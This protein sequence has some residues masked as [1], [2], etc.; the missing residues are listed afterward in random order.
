MKRCRILLVFVFATAAAVSV[1]AAG[2]TK[3]SGRKALSPAPRQEVAEGE[4][5]DRAADEAAIRKAAEVFAEAYNAHDAAGVAALFAVEAEIVDD[6]GNTLHGRDAIQET[7]ASIFAETPE[8]TIEVAVDSIRFLSASL[9]VEFGSTS[10]TPAPGETPEKNRYTVLH[11]K[12]EG[13]WL[14]AL[15]RDTEGEEPT[16][17]ERLQP[18]GWL[19]GDW[20]DE[21]E[22]SVV[23]TSCRWTENRNYLL[24]EITVKMEG[25]DAM[26]VSQRI[27]WDPLTKRIKSWFF[28]SEGGYGES[29]WAREGD[30]W[31]IKATGVQRDGSVASATNLVSPLSQDAY[32]WQSTDRVVGNEIAPPLEVRIVRKPPEPRTTGADAKPAE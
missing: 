1:A 14:M 15:A 3:K 19:V 29:V 26:K 16:N 12:R 28:D 17:Y 30:Q 10:V 21:G 2:D 13:Q 7:F 9:A 27:G 31:I 4:V 6:V 18:L 22:D 20:V 5:L 32:V 25:R 24:Q 23:M 8:A 11:V